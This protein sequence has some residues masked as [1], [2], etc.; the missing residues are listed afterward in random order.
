[1]PG[2][3]YAVTAPAG[4]PAGTAVA[5]LVCGI[6]GVLLGACLLGLPSVAA[7]I[8]G[9]IGL[10]QTRN[11]ARAGRG[12]AIAGLVLGYVVFIPA[13]IFSILFWIGFMRG[14]TTGQ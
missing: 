14:V 5:S 9:H 13:L 1:M 6:A 2:P 4:P 12:L 7:V 8:L 3:A 11:N 10:N